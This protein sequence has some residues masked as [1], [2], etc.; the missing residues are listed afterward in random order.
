MLNTITMK[1]LSKT[2]RYTDGTPCTVD[3]HEV[4]T[5]RDAALLYAV[6]QYEDPAASTGAD[7]SWFAVVIDEEGEPLEVEGEA[8]CPDHFGIESADVFDALV[9][10][11][12]DKATAERLLS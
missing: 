12:M 9:A 7:R 1:R 8:L 5:L 3:S 4:E 6:L 2:E 11:G 10:R